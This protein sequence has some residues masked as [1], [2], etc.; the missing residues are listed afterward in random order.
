MSRLKKILS[1]SMQFFIIPFRIMKDINTELFFRYWNKKF[2]LQTFSQIKS[3]KKSD[4]LFILGT[5]SSILDLSFEQF[6]KISKH[7]SLGLNFFLLHEFV[8]NFISLE[9]SD[10]PI[11]KSNLYKN[12]SLISLRKNQ[13]KNSRFIIRDVTIENLL[14]KKYE[15]YI[16][17]VFL[18]KTT[19]FSRFNLFGRNEKI[20]DLYLKIIILFKFDKLH[21]SLLSKR[22]SVISCIDFAKK[23][24]YRKIVLMGID[25]SNC[26]YF[27]DQKDNYK[28]RFPLAFPEK[29]QSGKVHATH[30]ESIN[31]ATTQFIIRQ[32]NKKIFLDKKI[33]IFVGTKKSALYPDLKLFDWNS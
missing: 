24:G 32:F 23:L 17:K 8:P 15:D 16:P 7:D 25:L 29:L 27:Y 5:G 6:L 14:T 33:E 30:D 2:G 4:T 11:K 3:M 31:F 21:Y 26:D 12:L 22:S 19:L 20:F 9:L 10:N 18:K 1:N 13:L 28:K